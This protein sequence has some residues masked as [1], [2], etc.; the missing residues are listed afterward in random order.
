[1][2]T[3]SSPIGPA[4]HDEGGSLCGSQYGGLSRCIGVFV[5]RLRTGPDPSTPCLCASKPCRRC[6]VGRCEVL[7]SVCFVVVGR[8]WSSDCVCRKV[9]AGEVTK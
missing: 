4:L 7:V 6:D 1:M 5:S 3:K 9:S 8:R 2:R